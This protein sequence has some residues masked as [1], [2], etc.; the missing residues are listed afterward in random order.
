MKRHLLANLVAASA[1]FFM[2]TAFAEVNEMYMPNSA[3]GFLV[4]TNNPCQID[5]EKEQFPYAAYETDELENSYEGC[6]VRPEGAPGPF[7]AF[8]NVLMIEDGHR[9]IGSF[10]QH[11][12]SPIKKRWPE[13]EEEKP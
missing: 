13:V 12:F 2:S 11:L 10:R 8:V 3:G 1:A 4:L 6:W 9:N 5:A 7:V